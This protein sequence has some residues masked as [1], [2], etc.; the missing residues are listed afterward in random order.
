MLLGKCP[1]CGTCYSGWALKSPW[2][3]ICQR[4]GQELEIADDRGNS[5]A[6]ES[7][8]MNTGGIIKT[9]DMSN[10]N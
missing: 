4:C 2:Y 9:P 5:S 6:S 3:Q 10:H 8:G 1:K 7:S